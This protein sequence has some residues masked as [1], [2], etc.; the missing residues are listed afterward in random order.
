MKKDIVFVNY[1]LDSND[2]VVDNNILNLCSLIIKVLKKH[3]LNKSGTC[4]KVKNENYDCC[5]CGDNIGTNEIAKTL[6]CNHT[7]HK[8]C[9]NKWFK[10]K[11]TCPL[12]K[13]DLNH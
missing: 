8:K 5:I 11:F 4:K 13:H 9:I 7:F 6:V 10:I 1:N 3:K 12:C 2:V